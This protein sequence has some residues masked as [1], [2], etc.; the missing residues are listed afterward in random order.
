ME[1]NPFAAL[2]E[3]QQ[4]FFL[5]GQTL[6]FAFR[7]SSLQKLRTAILDHD[8]EFYEALFKDLHKSRFESYAT[9]IG[10]VLEELSFHLKHLKKWMKPKKVSS[11]IV[12]FPA[13]SR[14]TFEPLGG[15]G[16]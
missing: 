10:F 14:I 2:I 11:G 1:T 7:K 8:E 13:K 6:D 4:E 3:R 15:D 12:S 9:E 5:T 16:F